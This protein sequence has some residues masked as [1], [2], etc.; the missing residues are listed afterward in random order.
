MGA[1]FIAE[2]MPYIGPEIYYN[3]LSETPGR[4]KFIN[5][6]TLLKYCGLGLL[7]Y[8]FGALG[9]IRNRFFIPSYSKK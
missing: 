8:H 7:G 4:K 2:Q 1:Y 3:E 6:N 9:G 5:R